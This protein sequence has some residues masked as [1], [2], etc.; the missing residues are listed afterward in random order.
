MPQVALLAEFEVKAQDLDL[1][2]AAAKRELAA[3]RA[4]EPGCLGF[5]VVLFDDEVGK[6]AFVEV[7]EDPA[8]ADAHRHTPHFTAFFEEIAAIDVIWSVR[9]GKALTAR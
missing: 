9:R 5:D 1:F 8:A 4:T 6:G 7:F 3:V 2:L